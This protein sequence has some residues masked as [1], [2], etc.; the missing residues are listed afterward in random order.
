VTYFEST[1]DHEVTFGDELRIGAFTTPV[2]AGVQLA[3]AQT[4]RIERRVVRPRGRPY[5][6]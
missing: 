6:Q 3:F 1:H 5:V 2:Q 4:E